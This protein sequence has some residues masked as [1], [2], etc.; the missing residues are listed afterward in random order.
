[1]KKAILVI[2]VFISLLVLSVRLSSLAMGYF[3]KDGKS[4][5][6]VLSF[7][8]GAQVVIDEATLGKTPIENQD[9][10]PGDYLIKISAGEKIWQGR[11]S[12]YPGT[13]TVVN[14]DL[15]ASSTTAAGE[16][17]TLEKGKGVTVISYPFGAAVEVD[18]KVVGVTPINFNLDEAEHNFVINH[19]N[20]A[21]RSIKAFVPNGFNLTI[22]V[23]LAIS[24]ADLVQLQTP[25]INQTE[26]VIVKDTPTNFLRVREKPSVTAKEVTRVKPGDELILLEEA[27]GWSRVRLPNG[28]E[29]YVSNQYIEKSSKQ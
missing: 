10:S 27:G 22:N 5:I 16:V 13:I 3:I 26:K 12:L 15:S 8:E 20:Y 7:P 29:G 19:P 17:L 11:V 18:G 25:A 2:L 4:G 28:S 21:K 9:L 6:K 1:M 24:E 23:D 14:R